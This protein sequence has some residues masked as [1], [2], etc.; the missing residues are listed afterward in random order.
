MDPHKSSSLD[1]WFEMARKAPVD[2]PLEAIKTH[3]K[4]SE[5][6][7]QPSQP[8]RGTGGS[9][10]QH[11][12]SLQVAASL[13]LLIGLTAWMVFFHNAAAPPPHEG[14]SAFT[15]LDTYPGENLSFWDTVQAVSWSWEEEG[16]NVR[17]F[18]A[19]LADSACQITVA[20]ELG[21]PDLVNLVLADLT[22]T[23]VAQL[24]THARQA[25][26]DSSYNFDLCTLKTGNYQLLVHTVTGDAFRKPVILN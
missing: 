24:L 1:R 4:Q 26:A 9:L 10:W 25:Q 16:K 13:V 17:C 22:G 7:A 5:H 23:V 18:D 14:E 3:L 21:K 8:L 20:L 15:L 2:M 11:P 19:Y 12:W 6:N